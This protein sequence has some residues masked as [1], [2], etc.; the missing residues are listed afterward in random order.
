R[1][2]AAHVIVVDL[3][4]FEG[5]AGV[6]VADDGDDARVV[7]QLGGDLDGALGVRLIVLDDELDAPAVDAA[8]LVDL[9]DGELGGELHGPAVRLV[10]GPGDR[11]ADR[12]IVGCAAADDAEGRG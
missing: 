3:G 10:D 4:G 5:G 8:V 1:D 9:G 6:E 11:D 2:D 12:G 7:A